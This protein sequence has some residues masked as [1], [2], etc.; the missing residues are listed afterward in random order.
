MKNIIALVL[1]AAAGHARAGAFNTTCAPVSISTSV[2]TEI[3]GNISTAPTTVAPASVWAVKVTN[4][5]TSADLWSSE[6][7]AVSTF[8][9]HLGDQIAHAAAAPWNWLAWIINSSRNWYVISNG[10]SATTA[11]VCKTQ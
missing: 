8:G 3:T 1:F 10:A 11:E 5:S 6:D 7:V 2:P 4:L 9:A